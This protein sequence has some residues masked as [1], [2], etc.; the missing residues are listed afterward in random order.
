MA[1]GAVVAVPTATSMCARTPCRD[2]LCGPNFLL[3]ASRLFFNRDKIRPDTWD[4][5]DNSA[6][7]YRPKVF[8]QIK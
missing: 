2:S 7:Q 5:E 6:C 4:R 8:E 3:I 1:L